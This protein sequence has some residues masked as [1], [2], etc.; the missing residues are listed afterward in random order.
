MTSQRSP[1]RKVSVADR[2]EEDPGR[3]GRR[4]LGGR[5]RVVV[6]ARVVLQAGLQVPK[7]LAT[8]PDK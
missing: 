2:A 8:V 1:V 3:V 6:G 4:H 7:T 5:L